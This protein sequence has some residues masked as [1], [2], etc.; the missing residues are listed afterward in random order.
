MLEPLL[1]RSAG[2][3]QIDV[4]ITFLIY[5]GV[6]MISSPIAGLVGM[7]NVNIIKNSI[8]SYLLQNLTMNI[9]IYLVL[10][11]CDKLRHPTIVS[12]C[13][14]GAMAIAF[15]YRGPVPFIHLENSLSVI[16]AMVALVGFGFALVMV[17][18][19]GR[20]QRAALT[21]CYANDI[22]TSIMISG[23]DYSIV[24]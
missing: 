7:I 4:G 19:F 1:K 24:L 20:T 8:Y 18:S 17:S 13:G 2:A 23:Q 5:A 22:N 10:K 9:Y 6:F 15:L 16:M 11:I 21:L 12:I 14:N 3:S